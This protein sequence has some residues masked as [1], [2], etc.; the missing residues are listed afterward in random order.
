MN[1]TGPMTSSLLARVF[2]HVAHGSVP[3]GYSHELG[4]RQGFLAAFARNHPD[5]HAAYA[6]WLAQNMPSKLIAIEVTC[7]AFGSIYA[8]R[9]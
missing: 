1:L 4:A 2:A 9:G 5:V 8:E 3:I 7:R 6:V